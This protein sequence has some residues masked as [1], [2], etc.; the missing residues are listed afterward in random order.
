MINISRTNL[1]EL[2]DVLPVVEQCCRQLQ[3]DFYIVGALAKEIWFAAEGIVTGGTKDVDFAIFVSDEHQFDQ[4]K[5]ALIDNHGFRRAKGNSF[6]L[7]APNG[8]QI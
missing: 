8:T 3:I 1:N 7:F 4:L 6:V 5:S 2:R